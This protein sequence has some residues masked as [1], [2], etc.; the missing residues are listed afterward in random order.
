[1][2][3]LSLTEP[4]NLLLDAFRS[5]FHAFRTSIQNAISSH[6][7]PV[8]IQRLKDDLAQYTALVN[9]HRQIFGADEL[10]VIHSNLAIMHNDVDQQHRE[11]LDESNYGH[12]EIIR[13]IPTGGRGRPRIVIDP[14]FLRWA[15]TVR[16]TASIANFLNVSRNVVRQQL[17]D[18]G[19]A[20]P[21]E[22]P[23]IL[24][25]SYRN[26]ESPPEGDTDL[27]AESLTRGNTNTDGNSEDELLEPSLQELFPGD[28][29]PVVITSY[30]GP[31][32]TL[33]DSELDDLIL[34]LRSHFRR[35]GI[36]MLHGMLQRL[37]HRVPRARIQEALLRIDPVRRVFERIRIRRREY[38]VPGPM[39]LWHHDGQHGLI[40]WG[41]VIH[42]FI[43]GYSRLITG[44]RAHNNNSAQAVLDLFLEAC[45]KYGVPSRVREDHGLENLFVAAW[46][47]QNLG[48]GRGSYI[49]G[50]LWVDVTA[51]VTSAWADLFT[52]LEIQH[53]LNIE[54][55]HHIWLLHF[56]FLQSINNQ[57]EFFAESWN[58][59]KI[60]IRNGRNR[61]PADMFTF[62]TIVHGVRGARLS[63][64]DNTIEDNTVLSDNELET[65]GIDW[66]EIRQDQILQSLSANNPSSEPPDSW[67]GGG[68]PPQL[69]ELQK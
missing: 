19:I 30:T 38:S 51:Q 63:I 15:Y 12:P 4:P 28:Q 46:M 7:D 34:R 41:I 60:Q 3:T 21:Q 39:Y 40:R 47:E 69:N 59:H 61:S 52:N 50:R 6:A 43:D 57:L 26:L 53:G 42:G 8:V 54:N 16:S 17:L 45:Q 32:S 5:R 13:R 67:L 24:G 58:Q 49:W 35:A 2:T 23:Y 56:L 65:Y 64:E 68:Q 48:S 14:D 22:Q 10:D 20:E 27:D 55:P 36:T 37:G 29:A 18:L 25:E 9:E 1:M 44:L 33:S 62:D 66:Q 31:I 11:A